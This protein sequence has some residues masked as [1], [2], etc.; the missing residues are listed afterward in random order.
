LNGG[1]R[2]LCSAAISLLFALAFAGTAFGQDV[3]ISGTVVNAAGAPIPGVTVRVEGTDARTSTDVNG[4]YRIT[5]PTTAT[6]TFAHVGSKPQVQAVGGRRTVDVTMTN[7]TYLEEVVVTAYTEQRRADIT[8]AVASA[9]MDAAKRQTQASVIK[10][11]DATVPG[12][13]VQSSGSPGSRSTVRIRGISSFQNNDP[14]YIVDGT[15]V[16]DSYVNFLNPEDIQS[17]QV[18]KDASAASIYGSRASNGVIVIETTKNEIH[19]RVPIIA[20]IPLLGDLFRYDSVQEGRRE[21]LII[22]TPRI[23]NNKTDSDLVK[24]IES[25][26]MS[27]ILSDVINVHGEAGLRS[28][29]DEWYDGEMESIYPN[30]VPEEGFLPLS[31]GH[32]SPTGEP[33]LNSPSCPPGSAPPAPEMPPAKGSDPM[34]SPRQS[35]AASRPA[36]ENY[37]TADSSGAVQPARYLAPPLEMPSASGK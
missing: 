32:L 19:R 16:Q 2:W 33:M 34:S 31:K 5:A 15:P 7:V 4:V 23:I 24:Q 21:V 14:L 10:A 30:L 8:G 18:L 12:V 37:G 6:L 1:L 9:D 29:C 3:P 28:R 27:W 26:R 17:I 11:L 13:T 36:N 25:S 35:P 20:D 22:L